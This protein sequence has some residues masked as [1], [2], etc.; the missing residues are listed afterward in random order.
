VQARR[1]AGLKPTNTM[2][3]TSTTEIQPEIQLD[4]TYRYRRLILA[5]IAADGTYWVA[6]EEQ[7]M[8]LE[9]IDDMLDAR[10]L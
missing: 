4:G 3:N 5:A 9:Q 7:W 6:G 10:Q 2:T 1:V 8:S